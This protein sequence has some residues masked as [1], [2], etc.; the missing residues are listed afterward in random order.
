MELRFVTLSLSA[1]DSLRSELGVLTFFEDERPLRGYAGLCD[2]RLCGRLSG[3]LASR[4]VQGRVGEK[5]L[6]PAG[7]RLPFERLLLVGLGQRSHFDVEAFDVAS[8]AL[9]ESVLGLRVRN[10]A[11]A[12]PGRSASMI[13]PAESA[14]RF[15]ASL[16]GLHDE[17]D[18]LAVV[19]EPEALREMSPILE[20]ER[21][22][23]RRS[24]NS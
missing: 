17:L 7:A 8:Q 2:W 3:L 16:G 24:A 22:R 10:V 12:L 18:E 13:G 6:L 14:R 5:T 1:I 11:L 9:V 21:R 23:L 4:R 15:M 19:D 20:S